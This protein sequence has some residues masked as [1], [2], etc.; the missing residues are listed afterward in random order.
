MK[1]AKQYIKNEIEK[2]ENWEQIGNGLSDLGDGRLATLREILRE[3][4]EEKAAKKI[5]RMFR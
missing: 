2:L 5:R 1:K 4:E 3:M